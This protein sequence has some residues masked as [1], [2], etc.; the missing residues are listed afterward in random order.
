MPTTVEKGKKLQLPA[1]D[2]IEDQPQAEQ[3]G[4]QIADDTEGRVPKEQGFDPGGD[5][6]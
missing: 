2:H 5:N 6:H 4:N 3:A 1:A